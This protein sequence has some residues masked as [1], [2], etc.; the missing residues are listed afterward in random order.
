MVLAH[1]GAQLPLGDVLDELVDGQLE[2][3]AGGRRALDST[4]RA[5][6][7]VGL[8]EHPA[9]LPTDLLVIARFE[10]VQPLVVDADIAN[11]MSRQFP[12]RVE[13]PVLLQEP[14]PLEIELPNPTRRVD[15]DILLHV[16]KEILCV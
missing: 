15:R 13:P 6:A 16:G 7:R 9:R 5:V 1:G 12:I 3:D 2:G 11:Q 4:E 8:H 14:D 10:P